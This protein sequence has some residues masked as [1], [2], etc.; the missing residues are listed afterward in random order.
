ML[1]SPKESIEHWWEGGGVEAVD[2]GE[3]G[4]EGVGESCMG[5]REEWGKWWIE[6]TPSVPP[7]LSL[8]PPSASPYL[9]PNTPFRTLRDAHDP[10][11]DPAD[12]I[13]GGIFE[14]VVWKPLPDGERRQMDV[15]AKE[16]AKLVK[17]REGAGPASDV[18]GNVGV[19]RVHKLCP[20]PGAGAWW[21]PLTAGKRRSRGW[22]WRGASAIWSEIVLFFGGRVVGHG[23]CVCAHVVCCG[24]GG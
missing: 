17:G 19:E 6:D 22:I 18:W 14:L 9:P 21:C 3:G 16:H 12:S 1:G 23:L 15:F 7:F 24:C 11:G 20:R 13:R 5:G 10:N 8:L 2:G 4:E